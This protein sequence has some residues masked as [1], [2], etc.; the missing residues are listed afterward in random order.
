MTR[1]CSALLFDK[2]GTLFDFQATWGGWFAGVLRDLSGGDKALEADLAAALSFDLQATRFQPDS[3]AIAGTLE[4][5]VTRLIA[6]GAQQERDGLRVL[7]ETSSADVA[8]APVTA[9]GPLFDRFAAAGLPCGLATN[10]A[11]APARAQLDVLGLL[12]AF[13]FIAGY[14][15]GF[16]AK[17][18]PGQ[19]LAFADLIGHAPNGIAMIGDSTH[20]L[21]AARA[22][23]MIAVGVL[24]GPSPRA[25]L[26]PHADLLVDSIA[27]LPDWL[28]IA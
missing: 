7:L 18:E 5:I 9:L 11:E 2:D 1:K 4:E 8:P 23:G 25:E 26:A 3:P 27:D 15:S 10:D 17:P 20:D 16:G 28:G 12:P 19:L 24:T 13:T 21:E 22:A 14:D 6:A